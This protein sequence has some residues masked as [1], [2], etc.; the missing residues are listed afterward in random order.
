MRSPGL[1]CWTG[2]VKGAARRAMSRALAIRFTLLMTLV[3]DADY[4]EAIGIGCGS[5]GGTV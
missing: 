5:S 3:P 2:R 4:P 1:P